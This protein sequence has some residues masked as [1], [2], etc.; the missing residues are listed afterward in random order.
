MREAVIVEAV[1][2]PIGRRKGPLAEVHPIDLGAT[3]LGALTERTGIDP[4]IVDDVIWGCVSQVGE[5]SMNV[6]RYTVLGAGW[7]ESVPATTVDR[8]CGSSQQAAMFAAAGIIAGHCDIA[9]AGGTESMDRVPMFSSVQNGP[10]E[11]NTARGIVE[12]YGERLVPQG[13][14]AEMIAER[15]KLSR[16][17][18]DGIAVRS[19]ERAAA[20]IA[21]GA[22]ADQ[23]VPVPVYGADGSV[24]LV[25]TDSGVRP[26]TSL[27]VLATLQSP[28]V[29]GG[30]I[31]AG[32]ASQI[33]D[34]SAALLLMTPEKAREHGLRP[35]VRITHSVVVGVDPV[36]ML[37]GPIPA[38]RKLLD[39]AGLSVADIGAFEVN[40]AFASVIGAW[41]D[42]IGADPELLNV[43]GGA[44][45]L[46]H[47]LGASGA[48]VMTTLVH[49]M[50]DAGVR[51]GVQAIC[52]G[53]GLANAT[54]F[55]LCED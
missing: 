34:G 20:A 10:G 42:E 32:N 13:V 49:H 12:R 6:G 16:E 26:G 23:I 35:I 18:V 15:W 41:E 21:S 8:Q 24:T 40:E 17:R 50:R 54:L 43:H 19:H 2:T 46:G 29:E 5:Q 33:S 11:P 36:T 1:R 38:T 28:F 9:V 55:E 37:T 27:D 52:E 7:P 22:F 47:P 39:R 44:I 45:A 14:G 4:A 30:V 31:H 53:G 25:D 51:Y 48:R 3:V